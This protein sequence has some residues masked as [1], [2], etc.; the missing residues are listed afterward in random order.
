MSTITNTSF[1][2]YEASLQNSVI[3]GNALRFQA[4][5]CSWD[6]MACRRGSAS[7]YFLQLLQQSPCESVCDYLCLSVVRICH[8]DSITTLQDA[9]VKVYR[10]V[11][12]IK[13]K[14]E[15]RGDWGKTPQF[16]VAALESVDGYFFFHRGPFLRLL[17]S[18][19]GKDHGFSSPVFICI[20]STVCPDL[21]TAGDQT[22][23]L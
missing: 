3:A 16:H 8:R 1:G 7:R 21:C 6:I 2:L 19:G 9:V 14:D 10:C 13:M 17:D 5:T 11:A 22:L 4:G 12:G 15:F 23:T 20:F 18:R